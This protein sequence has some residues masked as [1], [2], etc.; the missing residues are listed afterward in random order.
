MGLI[1][2]MCGNK[3]CVLNLV[4]TCPLRNAKVRE[5]ISELQLL[6]YGPS[7]NMLRSR[8]INEITERLCRAEDA[9]SKAMLAARLNSSRQ[10]YDTPLE[11]RVADQDCFIRSLADKVNDQSKTIAKLQSIC[12]SLASD[13]AD[14]KAKK[15]SN[16]IVLTIQ[17]EM[18]GATLRRK[19]L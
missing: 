10:Y 14:L 7:S 8:E 2:A 9:A 17:N 1:A 16:N 18:A 13:V 5:I 3:A 11:K 6:K 15:E 4:D 12:I 19:E